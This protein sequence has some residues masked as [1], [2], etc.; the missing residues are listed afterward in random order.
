MVRYCTYLGKNM[1]SVVDAEYE[2]LLLLYYT[3][4]IS[5]CSLLPLEVMDQ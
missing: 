5:T 1:T 3:F 4:L 2:S